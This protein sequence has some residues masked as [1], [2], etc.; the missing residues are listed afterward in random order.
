MSIFVWQM[1]GSSDILNQIVF[2][3]DAALLSLC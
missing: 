2:I 3:L 1:H